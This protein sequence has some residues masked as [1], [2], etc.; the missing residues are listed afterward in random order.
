MGEMITTVAI[1]G[2]LTAVAVPN[3]MR[4]RMQVN[5]ELVKQNLKLIH[6]AMN[7]DLTNTGQF[8]AKSDWGFG[9]GN[10]EE[11]AI[12][13]S[14]SSIDQKDYTTTDYT[15]NQARSTYTFRTCPKE[16]KWGVSGDKCF[17][18]D[19]TGVKEIGRWEAGIDMTPMSFAAWYWIGMKRKTK[20]GTGIL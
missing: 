2:T 15:T 10:E 7:R 13:A 18:L 8:P 5:M 19:P 14:L 1:V 17:F 12:T 6:E 4:I 11:I 16:G 9:S 20:K 3:Y